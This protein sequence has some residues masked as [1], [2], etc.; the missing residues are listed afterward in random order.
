MYWYY[1]VIN[2]NMKITTKVLLL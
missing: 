1:V 2:D